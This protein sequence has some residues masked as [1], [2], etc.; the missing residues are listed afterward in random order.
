MTNWLS[1][2][3]LRRGRNCPDEQALASF[4]DQTCDREVR[5]RLE[6]HLTSCIYCRAL[7]AE[8]VKTQPTDKLHPI[9]SPLLARV[10][11]LGNS[12]PV[13]LRWSWLPLTIA[14]VG[15][16]AVLLLVWLR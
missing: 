5:M 11:P 2:R 6:D 1:N 8:S 10:G 13:R 9:P 15:C 12:T 16:A 7:V 4:L 14:P 3:D